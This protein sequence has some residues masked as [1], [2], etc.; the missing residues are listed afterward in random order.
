MEPARTI[1]SKLGG[2]SKVALIVGVH[3]TRASNWMRGKDVGG[4]DGRIPQ[5]HHV[6]LLDYAREHGVDLKAEDFLL[7]SRENAA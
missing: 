6:R 4:T 3:R 2:P 1:I 7:V 5:D